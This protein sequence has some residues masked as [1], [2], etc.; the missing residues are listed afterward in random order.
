MAS[1]FWSLLHRFRT[2]GR[3]TAALMVP[4]LAGI[5]FGYYY[6]W[7]VGQFDP[8]SAYHEPVW[9][10]PLVADS[11]NAVVLMSIV[12]VGW[13]FGLRNRVLDALAFVHMAYVGL[14]TTYLFLSYPDQ[15]GTFDWASVGEGNANPVLFLSHMGMPLEALVLVPSLRGRFRCPGVAA[16]ALW[17]AVFLWADYGAPALRPAPF[18]DAGPEL[19]I[20]S[21]ILMAVCVAAFWAFALHRPG[22]A[23]VPSA[24]GPA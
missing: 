2:D 22:T 12:L 10:W 23:G 5:V 9:T 13:H 8:S 7:D 14:W 4:N 21:T 24:D 18:V 16:M 11:P 19:W 1:G 17:G 15:L 6:Y 3:L 20:G